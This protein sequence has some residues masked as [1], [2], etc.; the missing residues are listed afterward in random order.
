MTDVKTREKITPYCRFW[1][2]CIK[3]SLANNYQLT[4]RRIFRAG[5]LV[6]CAC[7]GSCIGILSPYCWLGDAMRGR[8]LK[9]DRAD[10]E[11]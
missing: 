11:G 7:E 2:L 4:V 9:F 1:V 3:G 10:A 5:W 8:L 6:R